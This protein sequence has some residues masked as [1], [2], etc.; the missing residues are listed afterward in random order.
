MAGVDNESN[1]R[2]QVLERQGPYLQH[3]PV[4]AFAGLSEQA[5]VLYHQ[6]TGGPVRTANEEREFLITRL[7]YIAEV[8]STAVRLNSSWALSHAAMSLV[9]DRYEQT[10]RFSWLARQ[11]DHEELKKYLGSY[12]AKVA[13]INASL[14]PG[15]KKF[16]NNE[17]S[18][19][20]VEPP[21]KEER[22]HLERWNSLDLKTMAQRRDALAP[23]S[24][25]YAAKLSLAHFYVTV[26]QQFSSVSHYDMY[27]VSLLDLHK[28]PSGEFVLAASPYWPAILNLHNALFDII[29][30]H[31]SCVAFFGVTDTKGFDDLSAQWHRLTDRMTKD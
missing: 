5:F 23:L 13:K 24:E 12:Y 10:V 3:E 4:A 27:G 14:S 31:E 7:M 2:P 29:Q 19:W 30:C 11:T 15:L 1:Q 21:T 22:K 16:I 28:N 26:Y 17:D 25:S 8:T 20:G 9:R 6:L 18:I